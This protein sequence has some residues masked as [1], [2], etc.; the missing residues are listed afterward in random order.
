MNGCMV[1]GSFFSTSFNDKNID[2]M[3]Q[4]AIRLNEIYHDPLFTVISMRQRESAGLT[5]NEIIAGIEL[6]RNL[7]VTGEKLN[8]EAMQDEIHVM[9]VS[10]F[11]L[12]AMIFIDVDVFL[13]GRKRMKEKGRTFI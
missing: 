10:V 13:D 1:D 2:K 6:L 11:A 5:L 3:K 12:K 4:D 8:I 7:L 9:K